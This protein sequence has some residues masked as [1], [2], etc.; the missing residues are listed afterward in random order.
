[1]SIKSANSECLR[2]VQECRATLADVRVASDVVPGMADHVVL[3]S[4]P[5]ITWDRMC[6]PMRGAIIGATLFEGWAKTPEEAVELAASGDLS[7]DPCHDHNAVGPMAGIITKSMAV[8]VV[9]D[10]ASGRETYAALYMGLGKVLRFGAYDE[11]VLARLRWMNREFAPLLAEAIR[12]SGGI[13]MNNLMA[14]ALHMSDELHN[15]NKAS[16]GLLLIA[17]APH[18]AAVGKGAA[19]KALSFLDESTHFSLSTVMASCKLMTDA[20]HGIDRCAIVTAMARNGT[21]FGIRVSGLGDRWF[22]APA[23]I[24]DGV[25]FPGY[26]P[27]DANPDIGDSSITET[28]GVGSM[29]LAGA[30]AIVQYIGG[31]AHSAIESTRKMYEITAEEHR[32]FTI[33]A[34]DFRGTPVGIDIR[35]V[36]ETGIEPVIN[37]G[38]A[39]K[40]PGIGQIGA[41]LTAAPMACFVAALEAFAA[42][43]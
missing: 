35:K 42:A 39:H 10:Q 19:E 31:T 15:R 1:M 8:Q 36:V 20:G 3:H 23:P 27:E 4:G 5:P 22:T 30:P 16:N 28:A 43:R 34:L 41:G 25:F 17:L 13:D 6:G 40:K 38:I 32:T 21:E 11:S 26:G 29:A 24:V 18:L 7:F 33:P 14:Q 2:R 9:R 12:R 37:T